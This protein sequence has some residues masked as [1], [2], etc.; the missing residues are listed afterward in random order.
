MS[1][2]KINK[3]SS[4]KRAMFFDG[5]VDIARYD[6]IKYPQLD[7]FTDK[8]LGFFWRPE[9][10]DILRDNKD[11]KELQIW[12]SYLSSLF[13]S[14]RRGLRR[15]PFLRLFIV[16]LILTSLGIFTLILLL[17]LITCLI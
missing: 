15:G 3:N 6:D 14:W 2:F 5:S 13:Q 4:K 8:Q 10:V 17:Y 7:K 12:R 9:E 11:F 16:D 1:V